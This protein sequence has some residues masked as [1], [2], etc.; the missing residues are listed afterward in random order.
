MTEIEFSVMVDDAS[1]PQEGLRAIL[2]EFERQY[3]VKVHLTIIGWASGWSEIMKFG[4]YGQGPDVSEI[5]TTWL[6]GI[7]AMNALRPFTLADMRTLGKPEDFLENSWQSCTLKSDATLWAIP[8]QTDTRLFY[9]RP[10]IFDRAGITDHQSVFTSQ[11]SLVQA[12]GK[13][14]ESGLVTPI[15]LVVQRNYNSVYEIA[16]WVWGAGGH[17]MAPDGLSVVMDQPEALKGLHDYFSLRSFLREVDWDATDPYE[18]FTSGKTAMAINGPFMLNGLRLED[19][20]MA[21]RIQVSQVPGVPFVGGTNL[22]I[23]KHSR[24]PRAAVDLVN[25]LTRQDARYPY[26]AHSALLPARISVLD[27]LQMSRDPLIQTSIRSLHAGQSFSNNRMWGF[28][29][30]KLYLILSAIWRELL[31]NPK[32]D[33]DEVI[34]R[35]IDFFVRRTNLTLRQ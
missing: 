14:F 5:G 3:H 17:F 20:E 16:S 6:G 9:Y 29:E 34:Q 31:E 8:W 35:N 12:S 25:F 27:E 1:Q 28:V 11:D 10:D 4:L 21:S 15:T 33:L 18:P 2:D 32:T 24:Q 23:W 13:I 26:I 30:E 19:P 7:A 22:M